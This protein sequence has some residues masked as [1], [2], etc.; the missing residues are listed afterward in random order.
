MEKKRKSNWAKSQR[1]VDR[2]DSLLSLK[3]KLFPSPLEAIRRQVRA[4]TT[5]PYGPGPSWL[6]Y[7]EY[8]PTIAVLTPASIRA[9]TTLD[10]A[11]WCCKDH[12]TETTDSTSSIRKKRYMYIWIN[13][14]IECFKLTNSFIP[15]QDHIYDNTKYINYLKL[16]VQLRNIVNT[17]FKLNS[18]EQSSRSINV[19]WI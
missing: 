4:S 14:N 19:A 10:P 7:S 17:M 12:S 9:R 2:R 8:S 18:V 16:A 6:A 3:K 5:G 15:R 1:P 11:R 13:Q